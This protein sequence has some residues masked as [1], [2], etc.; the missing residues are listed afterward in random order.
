ME[1][2]ADIMDR[3]LQPEDGGNSEAGKAIIRQITDAARAQME[4]I[5]QARDTQQAIHPG[6][7]NDDR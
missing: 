2:L 3:A 7:S 1:G 6:A 5:K 4:Y